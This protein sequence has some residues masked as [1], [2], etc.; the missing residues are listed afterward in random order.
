MLATDAFIPDSTRMDAANPFG[1]AG[2]PR[3]GC[4]EAAAHNG[5]PASPLVIAFA[6]ARPAAGAIFSPAFQASRL[7][8]LDRHVLAGGGGVW[9][10]RLRPR[11]RLDVYWF[12][13]PRVGPPHAD[14]T[15]CRS[16]FAP[17]EAAP[18]P[19]PPGILIRPSPLY[20]EPLR[21]ILLPRPVR[22][23]QRPTPEPFRCII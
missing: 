2:T 14:E 18:R 20:L 7:R 13:Q 1:I 23:F 21:V 3:P 19:S 11:P 22:A 17:R 12:A 5:A 10:A 15:K 6:V 8:S 4:H 16:P 9:A